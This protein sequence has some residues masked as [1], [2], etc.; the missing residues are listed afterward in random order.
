M[1]GKVIENIDEDEIMNEEDISKRNLIENEE[2]SISEANYFQ[3]QE[4]LG[5]Q[6]NTNKHS[7][8]IHQN[9][10]DEEIQK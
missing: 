10:P 1:K 3:T 9:I 7:I 5:E 2:N 6:K 4:I 8:V